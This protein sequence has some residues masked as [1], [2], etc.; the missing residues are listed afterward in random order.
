M[1]R[2]LAVWKTLLLTFYVRER[3]VSALPAAV[4]VAGS[5]RHRWGTGTPTV[6]SGWEL[7]EDRTVCDSDLGR[8][9]CCS[10]RGSH[11]ALHHRCHLLIFLKCHSACP[12]LQEASQVPAGSSREPGQ[13]QRPSTAWP[14]LAP[15]ASVALHLRCRSSSLSPSARSRLA[16]LGAAPSVLLQP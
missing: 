11:K 8:I 1:G 7:S 13:G 10:P 14:R 2:E 16:G 6:L 5:G 12:F 15:G 9:P 4:V 3:T